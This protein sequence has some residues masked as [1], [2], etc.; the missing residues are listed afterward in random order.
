[1][2]Y[3]GYLTDEEGNT[4]YPIKK[5]KVISLYTN[6]WYRI[7]KAI[8]NSEKEPTACEIKLGTR[9]SNQAP[10]TTILAIAT[11]YKS[12]NLAEIIT[13]LHINTQ[14]HFDKARI[15]YDDTTTTFYLDV[16]YALTNKT[17]RLHINIIASDQYWKLVDSSDVTEYTTA[18]EIDL[19][20]ELK[21]L[22][23]NTSGSNEAITLSDSAANYNY[24][25]IYFKDAYD[26]CGSREIYSPNGKYVSLLTGT[27]PANSAGLYM[28]SKTVSISGTTISNI[29]YSQ[30][31]IGV[32]SVSSTIYNYIYITR[33]EGYK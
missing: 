18:A 15:Q 21:V 13:K 8:A 31:V 33:V 1:M 23:N 28:C 12:A 24:L 25:K 2:N 11:A 30:N 22:Y 17:N 19:D 26:R 4:Y 7:A 10:M 29:G 9:Y 5:D 6:G 3:I 20:K 14:K 16:H 27:T 32:S